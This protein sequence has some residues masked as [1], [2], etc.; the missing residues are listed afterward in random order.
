[1]L[2]LIALLISVSASAPHTHIKSSWNLSAVTVLAPVDG[3]ELY[4]DSE[5]GFLMQA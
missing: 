1:M 5:V 4:I 3:V 2:F